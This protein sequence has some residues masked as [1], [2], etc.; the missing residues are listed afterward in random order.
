MSLC[1]KLQIATLALQHFLNDTGRNRAKEGFSRKKNQRCFLV[2]TFTHNGFIPMQLCSFQ[3]VQDKQ[4]PEFLGASDCTQHNIKESIVWR[5]CLLGLR[6]DLAPRGITAIRN[7]QRRHFW[8]SDSPKKSLKETVV[9][10]ILTIVLCTL[11]VAFVCIK[12]IQTFTQHKCHTL[13]DTTGLLTWK[14]NSLCIYFTI[15][16][17][18]LQHGCL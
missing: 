12:G 1:Y 5:S 16:P 4:G 2:W 7:E 6:L 10:I 8:D 18:T 15:N 11:G 9:S 3:F 13:R 14:R 17:M